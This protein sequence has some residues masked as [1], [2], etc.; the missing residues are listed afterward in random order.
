M[1]KNKDMFLTLNTPCREKFT[2]ITI[3]LNLTEDRVAQIFSI[4]GKNA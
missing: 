3:L 2:F 4:Y 1:R